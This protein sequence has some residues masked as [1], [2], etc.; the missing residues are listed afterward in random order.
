M[1]SLS[2][3][4]THSLILSQYPFPF[5]IDFLF[6]QNDVTEMDNFPSLWPLS[7]GDQCEHD[8]YCYCC[9]CCSLACLLARAHDNNKFF[10]FYF[11]FYFKAFIHLYSSLCYTHT[12]LLVMMKIVTTIKRTRDREKRKY[13]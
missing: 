3:S 11:I 1:Y 13:K 5:L 4:L 9:F 6:V 8:W 12:L 2:H 10:P 7:I